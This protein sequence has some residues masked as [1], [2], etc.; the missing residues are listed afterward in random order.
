MPSKRGP[1][2]KRKRIINKNDRRIHN[3]G[4][5][6]ND[7]GLSFCDKC[8]RGTSFY[9]RNSKDCDEKCNMENITDNN[10]VIITSLGEDTIDN[11]Q[12]LSPISLNDSH[13]QDTI[14]TLREGSSESSPALPP[15]G[16]IE[17][18]FANEQGIY[19]RNMELDELVRRTGGKKK[20]RKTK[21]KNL[22]KR[23]TK[24]K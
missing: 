23:K 16:D 1:K 4:R 24:K 6:R 8:K 13:M 11:Y 19:D 14:R 20:K 2:T 22:K 10:Q 9:D 12:E 21:R 7:E 18:R 5:P 15:Y 3:P 17:E